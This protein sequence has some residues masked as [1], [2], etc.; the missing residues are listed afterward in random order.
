MAL[1]EVA[2]KVHLPKLAQLATSAVYCSERQRWP[3][4]WLK[5]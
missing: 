2:P 3:H 1:S 4:M 5:F